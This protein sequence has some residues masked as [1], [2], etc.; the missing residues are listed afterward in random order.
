MSEAGENND[1]DGDG[2][3]PD[4]RA[5]ATRRL[6]RRTLVAVAV[7]LIAGAAAAVAIARWHDG[8]A[9]V[10]PTSVGVA[11]D[12]PVVGTPP[13]S[14]GFA[15]AV[16]RRVAA[17]VVRVSGTACQELQQG[18]GFVLRRGLVVTNAHVV[19]GEPTTSVIDQAGVRH[20][21]TVVL[22]D[23]VRD[24]AVLRIDSGGGVGPP[25]S[26]V[27][28]R[29]PADL[30]VFGHP[31]GGPLRVAPARLAASGFID[32]T[33]RDIYGRDR[34]DSRHL[35]ALAARLVPGD[36]GAPVV[37]SRGRVVAVAFAIDP[38]RA[39]VAYALTP[40]EITDAA[41]GITVS[42][43]AVATGRCISV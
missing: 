28:P 6:G 19:A 11:G 13:E 43:A 4:D 15:P 23:M 32:S 25:L 7:V 40:S 21:A 14:V 17:S 27:S 38:D 12:P 18:T 29:A 30:A 20:G 16:L 33:G 42:H 10:R 41:R 37:D 3:T 39:P 5:E 35:L 24:I 36:S 1:D 9:T 2:G 34:R 8:D 31:G 26:F 22:F